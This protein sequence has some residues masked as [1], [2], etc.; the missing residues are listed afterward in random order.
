[1][2]NI[3]R[4]LVPLLAA[5]AMLCVGCSTPDSTPDAVPDTPQISPETILEPETSVFGLEILSSA[6][7][8]EIKSSRTRLQSG[9]EKAKLYFN[10]TELACLSSHRV[11][12]MTVPQTNGGWADGELTAPDG[13]RV[14]RDEIK[15]PDDPS[16]MI[17]RGNSLMVYLVGETDYA[18]IDIIMTYLPIISIDIDGGAE[19]GG[20]LQGADFSLHDSAANNKN[21]RY[22]SSRAEVKLRGGSSSTLPK[23][24]IRLDLKTEDGENRKLPLFGMRSDDDWILTAMFSDESKV[25]DMTAWQLWREMNSRYPE[26]KGSCAPETRYVEVLL[27]GRYQGLYMFMEKFDAKT[28]RLEDGDSLFKATSWEVPD[29]AGL[30]SQHVRSLSYYAM[31]KK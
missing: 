18:V 15:L 26:V 27:N 7:L 5:L 23:K 10:G 17:E 14:V 11:F 3:K 25:R 24:S 2:K 4:L 30:R 20:T 6:E 19:L 9:D 31:E 29:S 21:L 1:M 8:D 22:S 13:Y 12:Y 16:L 28:M